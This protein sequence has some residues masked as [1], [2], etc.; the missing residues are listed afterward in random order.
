MGKI[1]NE[2]LIHVGEIDPDDSISIEQEHIVLDLNCFPDD[3][4]V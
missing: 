1:L 4:S 3:I 2:D